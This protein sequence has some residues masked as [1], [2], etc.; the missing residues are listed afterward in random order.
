MYWKIKFIFLTFWL[1]FSNKC[2]TQCPWTPLYSIYAAFWLHFFCMFILASWKAA[3]YTGPQYTRH[4]PCFCQNHSDR[5]KDSYHNIS[6]VCAICQSFTALFFLCHQNGFSSST[7]ESYCRFYV[8]ITMNDN[9]LVYLH[10]KHF[11]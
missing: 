8:S 11:T 7:T 3:F 10:K 1:I 2:M 4:K 6:H 5:R 9:R